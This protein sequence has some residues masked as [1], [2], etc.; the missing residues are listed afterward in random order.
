[1]TCRDRVLKA[2]AHEETDMVP[3][4]IDLTDEAYKKME[5]Y[6]GDQEFYEKLGG[7][8]AQERNESFTELSATLFRDMF[9]VVWSHEQE[10]DFGIVSNY[11]LKDPTLDGYTFPT[12]D[13]KLI[14]QKC[15]RLQ[16]RKDKFRM[17][18]I[19]FSLY[20]RAWTLRS[21]PEL[22]IDMIAEEDFVDELLEKIVAYNKAV[23]EIVSQYDIDCIFYGDDW[24]QQKGLIMGPDKW[25]RFIRPRVKELYA[26][27]KNKGFY[28]AQHSCGDI[29]E[30]FGDLV[31]LGLDIYNTFQPEIYDVEK[32]KQ[33]YGSHITFYGGI[34]TQQLL[35]FATPEQ[36]KMET[37]A[38]MDILGRGGGYI[39]APTHSIPGDVPVENIMALAETVQ[40]QDKKSYLS[41]FNR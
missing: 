39:V 14:R 35:P 12:P 32:M 26:Q 21:I 28:V 15:E 11:L 23:V 19:G 41:D 5:A 37:R 24:G 1:M 16:A 36:V 38:L 29:S 2:L 9:G 40:S 8:L 13:E 31:D 20:E 34:S 4:N 10:G 6:L 3:Y 27:A 33:L 18:I 30:L 7:H 17:Y 25:R 22:L